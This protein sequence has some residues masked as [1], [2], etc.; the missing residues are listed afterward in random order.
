[1]HNSLLKALA[2]QLNVDATE[3]ERR[4]QAIGSELARALSASDRVEIPSVGRF[5]RTNGSVRFEPDD[6]LL[7]AVNLDTEG[8]G[9]VSLPGRTDAPSPL[10]ADEVYPVPEDDLED[11]AF[12]GFDEEEADEDETVRASMPDEQLADPEV[13]AEPTD[14][15]AYWNEETFDEAEEED[16]PPDEADFH[17]EET[18]E[19]F[20][21]HEEETTLPLDPSLPEE[22][23]DNLGF[24]ELPDT[25]D[26]ELEDEPFIPAPDDPGF[27]Q[28][29]E[30]MAEE[31]AEEPVVPPGSTFDARIGDDVD[32][33]PALVP[34][35]SPRADR[36]PE[37]HA[38]A[39]PVKES[40]E[41]RKR[42]SLLPIL[43]LGFALLAALAVG[44]YL[45]LQP[46]ADR[47]PIA[48]EERNIATPTEGD[49]T[50]GD[51]AVGLTD[52][53]LTPQTGAPAETVTEAEGASESTS[54][55][56]QEPSPPVTE[57]PAPTPASEAP[58]DV[59]AGGWTIV[60]GSATDA[61]DARRIAARFRQQGHDAAVLY[62]AYGGVTRYRVVVRQFASENQA[63]A[64][65]QDAPENFPNDAWRLRLSSEL[66][67][68]PRQD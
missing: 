27:D 10:P 53:L 51:E 33:T 57:T 11:A 42:R 39:H 4:L 30:P 43:L 26:A 48:Q 63:V 29:D 7:Q 37:R 45:L 22:D 60:V 19:R 36:P 32:V 58:I 49:G 64:F 18:D 55:P 15:V 28:H 21:W 3:A 56:A 17:E 67:V 47:P 38:E 20:L 46:R 68:I 59:S 40:S 8:F 44:A 23:V 62:G 13:K 24:A 61:A 1:M 31:R 2:R 14:P 9:I 5:E 66:E 6:V 16:V 12:D 25:L 34:H 35:P 50:E 65:L 41:P 52:S 54:E